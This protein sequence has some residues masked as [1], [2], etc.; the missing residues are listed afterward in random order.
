MSARLLLAFGV[1]AHV[2]LAVCNWSGDWSLPAASL[3]VAIGCLGQLYETR[4]Q[5]IARLVAELEKARGEP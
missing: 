1:G 4:E 3:L 2:S 5:R